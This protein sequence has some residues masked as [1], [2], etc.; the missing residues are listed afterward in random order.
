M[1]NSLTIVFAIFVAYA[2]A[3][4]PPIPYT[5]TAAVGA[6]GNQPG[7]FPGER[8]HHVGDQYVGHFGTDGFNVQ[9]G[10]EG[11]LIPAAV[12]GGL[13]PLSDGFDLKGH[14]GF[15]FKLA[16]NIVSLASKVFPKVAL[17]SLVLIGLFLLGGCVNALICTFTPF[18]TISFPGLGVTKDTMRSYLTSDRISTTA[19]VVMDAIRKYKDMYEAL[20]NEID[21]EKKTNDK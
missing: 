1:K 19:T 17:G 2:S 5:T 13:L 9:S 7:S 11:Y 8:I 21:A 20:N 6:A 14:H 3:D 10:Y 16:K 15:L 12:E 4:A 18:C